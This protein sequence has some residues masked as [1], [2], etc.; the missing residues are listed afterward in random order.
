MSQ[1]VRGTNDVL[2]AALRGVQAIEQE[3]L[4]RFESFGYQPVPPS[5]RT[6]AR[7]VS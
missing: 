7:A 2:P 3:L 5:F 1:R 4:E 6:P